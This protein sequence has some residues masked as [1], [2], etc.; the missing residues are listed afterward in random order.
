MLR[1]HPFVILRTHPFVIL[2]VVA[3]SK[4]HGL[5]IRLKILRLRNAD[6]QDDGVRD[7]SRRMRVGIWLAQEDG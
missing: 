4:P 6:V 1:T 5:R 3:G 7:A 2:R